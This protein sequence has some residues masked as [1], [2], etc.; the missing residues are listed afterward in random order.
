MTT[1][2]PTA[3]TAPGRFRLPD[4]PERQDDENW[5]TASCRATAPC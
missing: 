5:K 2:K 3:R 4:P 1:T